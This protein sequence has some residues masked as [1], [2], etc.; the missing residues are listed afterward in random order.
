MMEVYIF[1]RDDDHALELLGNGAST[2]HKTVRDAMLSHERDEL[3]SW[4]LHKIVVEM[5]ECQYDCGEGGCRRPAALM[6][7]DKFLCDAHS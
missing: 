6:R 5:V 7:G 4:N 3:S 1:A 2:E